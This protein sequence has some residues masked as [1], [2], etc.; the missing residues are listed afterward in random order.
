MREFE[1]DNEMENFSCNKVK[2]NPQTRSGIKMY[3][4]ITK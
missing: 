2:K 1:K 4:N 3:T